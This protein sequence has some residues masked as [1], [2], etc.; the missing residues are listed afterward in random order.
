MQQ[1]EEITKE[2]LPGVIS[3]LRNHS[4]Y[5]QLFNSL[6]DFEA[7]HKIKELYSNEYKLPE[8]PLEFI[9]SHRDIVTSREN[10]KPE[11]SLDEN[12]N[13]DKNKPIEAGIDWSETAFGL[14]GIIEAFPDYIEDAY[15]YGINESITG[16]GVHLISGEAPFGED[17]FSERFG[18]EGPDMF[19]NAT[20]MAVGMAADFYMFTNP[21]TAGT[22]GTV[23]MAS[24]EA[25]KQASKR[26]SK[27]EL[28]AILTGKVTKEG[29]ADG[30]EG[31]T[32][33]AITRAAKKS[34]TA[35]E[36][37]EQLTKSKKINIV[38]PSAEMGQGI[39][40]ALAQILADELD[41]EWEK[42]HVIQAP[43]NEVY[44]NPERDI[45]YTGGSSSCLLY[46]SPSPRD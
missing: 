43:L 40:T 17:A 41:F 33:N 26:L 29:V 1:I 5:G 22:Y 28:G 31:L 46:T 18:E 20:A 32:K 11:H 3:Y 27:G 6:T 34:D 38:I 30:F 7:Y 39:S 44:R 23:R 24:K 14:G 25:I 10:K 21:Y 13:L 16:L 35:E 36:M 15:K 4:E 8:M 12:R 19:Q 2:Q 9:S 37:I 42:V 45:Q